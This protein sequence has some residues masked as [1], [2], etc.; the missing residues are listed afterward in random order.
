ME[1]QLTMGILLSAA[2]GV[3]ACQPE[4][5]VDEDAQTL[6]RIHDAFEWGVGIQHSGAPPE[7]GGGL[8]PAVYTKN[9][10]NYLP[11]RG[12][13]RIISWFDIFYEHP[14]EAVDLAI[15]VLVH[16]RGHDTY[17]ELEQSTLYDPGAYLFRSDLYT[18]LPTGEYPV[19][20]SLQT[21]SGSVSER[22][23]MTVNVVEESDVPLEHP[24]T[25]VSCAEL[26]QMWPL[27]DG[28]LSPACDETLGLYCISSDD[29]LPC[30][31]L[32][33]TTGARCMAWEDVDAWLD[34]LE[35]LSNGIFLPK[36]SFLDTTGLFPD[37]T[38]VATTNPPTCQ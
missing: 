33:A 9:T 30:A 34:D 2:C 18:G 31:D 27:F 26:A 36:T 23:T 35:V 28:V 12:P 22:L 15:S 21:R 14:A 16:V 11:I 5:V 10:A 3:A 1:R 37:M 7:P 17:V 13:A 4:E 25:D 20:F 19:D 29:E 8:A 38:G 6:S 24:Y 32:A